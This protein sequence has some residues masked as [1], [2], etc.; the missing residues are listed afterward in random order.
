MYLRQPVTL[1]KN[2]SHKLQLHTLQLETKAK[3]L[4]HLAAYY[5]TL[6]P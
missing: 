2:T 6:Y 4:N 5:T 3:S 1:T